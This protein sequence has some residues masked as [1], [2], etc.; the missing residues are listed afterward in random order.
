MTSFFFDKEKK[1]LNW[2]NRFPPELHNFI[3]E[4]VVYNALMHPDKAALLRLPFFDELEPVAV[5][6]PC[7]QYE[8]KNNTIQQDITTPAP[9]K[10]ALPTMG[11]SSPGIK[12]EDISNADSWLNM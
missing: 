9:A 4:V 8:E 7:L 2:L 5:E 12:E 3:K 1:V 11:S 10:P 6:K